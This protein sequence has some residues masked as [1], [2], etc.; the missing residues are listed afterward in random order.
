MAKAAGLCG[1]GSTFSPSSNSKAFEKF[2]KEKVGRNEKAKLPPA[3]VSHTAPAVSHV[4]PG[5][6]D[7]DL[8]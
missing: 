5:F 8:D 3:E 1:K 2:I 7:L 6:E 4:A